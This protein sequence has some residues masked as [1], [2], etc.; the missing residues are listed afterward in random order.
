MLQ[1][2]NSMKRIKTTYYQRDA[3]KPHFLIIPLS[4]AKRLGSPLYFIRAL[5]QHVKC[6]DLFSWGK[7]AKY[8]VLNSL[9]RELCAN[10]TVN[11]ELCHHS[12]IFKSCYYTKR[13]SKHTTADTVH[14][15]QTNKRKITF[16]EW[17]ANPAC[18][19]FILWLLYC[20]CLS[21]ALVLVAW[22]G[23]YCIS[24]WVLLFRFD[25]LANLVSLVTV[26][27]IIVSRNGFND[28]KVQEDIIKI[29]NK[30][31]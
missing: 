28:L 11:V 31:C 20:I 23:S 7:I 16:W 25:V 15:L 2:K 19:L 9:P 13:N 14:T 17:V 22:C 8:C 29:H 12:M 10:A 30:R 21:F 26:A 1:S 6:Q 5:V 3:S 24:F 4:L 27:Y 18:R